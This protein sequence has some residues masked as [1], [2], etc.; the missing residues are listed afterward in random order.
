MPTPSHTLPVG[1]QTNRRLWKF[2]CEEDRHPGMWQR[3]FKHQCVAVGWAAQDGYHLCGESKGGNG[4]L[5]ARK[6]IQEIRRGD[7]VLVTL[8]NHRIGRIG[9][10]VGK[11]IEDSEWNPLVPPSRDCRHGGIGRRIL[12]R[13][14]FTVGPE[15]RERVVLLPP[16]T[17]LSTGELRRTVA[18][19]R[20]RRIESITEAMNE[21]ANWTALLQFKYEKSLQEYI[22]AYPHRLEDGLLPHPNKKVRERIFSDRSRPDVLLLDSN[23]K[24]VIVECKRDQPTKNDVHQLQAYMTNF[25]KEEHQMPRG[26]LVHGGARKLREEVRKV[27]DEEPKIELVQYNVEVDFSASH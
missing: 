12:V 17:R 9:E 1:N 13:W 4:W 3:W 15:D 8:R 10:V 19:I 7:Y 2:H 16:E 25:E 18:Q 6:A 27:A 11:A 26:I 23:D 24:P 5:S 21:P 14:D 20:S 22:A